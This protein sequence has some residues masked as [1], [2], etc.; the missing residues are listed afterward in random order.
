MHDAGRIVKNTVEAV[1]AE[2]ADDSCRRRFGGGGGIA[3]INVFGQLE[4]VAILP[5]DHMTMIARAP[6]RTILASSTRCS[7]GYSDL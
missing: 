7:R 2:V 6:D 4:T 1:T 5:L 3:R